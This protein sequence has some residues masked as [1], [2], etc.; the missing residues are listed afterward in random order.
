MK[1]PIY[2]DYASTTPVD[3]RVVR[4]ILK[5]FTINDN[6]GNP[7]S[8]FHK[9]GWDAAEA[10]DISRN[11]I[12]KL[13]KA[14]SIEIIFTSGATESNN[15]AIKGIAYSKKKYGNHIITSTIEHKS[16]INSCKYLECNGFKVTWLKP[17]RDGILNPD[18]LKLAI[19]NNT[20]LV[21]LMHVNNEIGTIQDI[22]SFG[23]ICKEKKVL[24]HIDASQSFGKLPI[25]IKKTN[26]DLLSFSGHKIYGPKGIGGLFIKRK[27]LLKIKTQIHGGNQE[28]GI[29]S[30]TLPVHQIVGI[31]AACNLAILESYKDMKKLK[32]FSKKLINA[33]ISNKLIKINGNIKKMIPTIIN[34]SF[35]KIKN[36]VLNYYL[37]DCAI[38]NGSSCNSK[39]LQPSYVLKSIGLSKKLASNSI[40]ISIGRFTQKREVDYII[41]KIKL[42]TSKFLNNIKKKV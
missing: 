22:E 38:S 11:Y 8:N 14:E 37:K 19:N 32:Y 42:M 33:F 36:K 35:K 10:V 40:R 25:N 4:K 7:A 16:V 26:I 5:Y 41:K 24:L 29:R 39:S 3:P 31:G 18:D 2:L 12:A 6:F 17:E 13:L 15:L 21:S 28:L 20:I 34:I 27:L 30:G 23:E 9:Y 1:F